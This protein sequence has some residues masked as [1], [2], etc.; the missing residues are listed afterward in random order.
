MTAV[1][2]QELREEIEARKFKGRTYPPPEAMKAELGTYR[3]A[4]AKEDLITEPPMGNR[5][6]LSFNL[7]A[8]VQP[9]EA[10]IRRFVDAMIYKLKVHHKKGRWEGQ[11]LEGMLDRLREEAGELEGAIMGRNLIE[12]LTEAADVA[13]FAL[14][15]ASIAT[16]RGK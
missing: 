15:I 4:G 11:D 12:I 5:V 6:V 7:P 8:E 13:N 14:I 2:E 16:E 10:D 3:S 1:T 9:Y